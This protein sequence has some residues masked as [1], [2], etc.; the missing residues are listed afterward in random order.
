MGLFGSHLSAMRVIENDKSSRHRDILL[1]DSQKLHCRKARSTKINN[2]RV[3]R[4]RSLFQIITFS[5]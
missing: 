2:Y 5:N 1:S 4:D 3:Y